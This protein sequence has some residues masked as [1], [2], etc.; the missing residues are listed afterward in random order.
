[1]ARVGVIS[2]LRASMRSTAAKTGAVRCFSSYLVTPKELHEALKKAPPSP[3]SS[4]PR[5]IPLCASWFLPNDPQKRTGLDVFIE[6]RIPKARFFDLDKVIDKRSPYPHMLPSSKDFAAAMSELGIRREDTVVIYD[7]QELGIFS[8]PRVGWTMKVFGHPK[9]HILNNFKL[10]IEEGLPTESGNVWTIEC[11]TYPIPEMNEDKVASFEEVRQVAIDSSKEGSKSVQILDA[12]SP[13]RWSGT[14]PEPREGL[15]SGHMPGSINIPFSAVLDSSTKAFLP[16]DKLKEVFAR[17]GVDPSKPIIS[18]CG[19][20][21]T[22]CVLE[23]A[24]NEA[25]FGSPEKSKVYDGSWTEWAQRV[26]SS[27]SLIEKAE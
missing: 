21:V 3:I 25:Q 26:K 17:A 5:V 24:L 6:K 16:A 12:R 27:E 4:E 11:G 9:V 8:A 22:A 10:W 14:E 19:T 20:G 23:T 18:S 1:M 13:G 7:S 2:P 15:S